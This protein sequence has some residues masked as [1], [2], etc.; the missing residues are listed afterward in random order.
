MTYFNKNYLSSI[1]IYLS[2]INTIRNQKESI[3]LYANNAF[4]AVLNFVSIAFLSH[5][6]L[7]QDYGSYKYMFMIISICVALGSLGFSQA[8]FYYIYQAQDKIE[9]YAYLNASRFCLILS[10]G[11]SIISF[12]ILNTILTVDQS[13]YAFNKF[14]GVLIGIIF[15]GIV[16]S[17]ELNVFLK[18]RCSWFYFTNIISSYIIRLMLFYVAYLYQADLFTY[19]NIWFLN[20]ILSTLINQLYLEFLYQGAPYKLSKKYILQI[21]KYSL[22]IG[23]A[24]FFGVILV[25]VDRVVLTFL[26][27]DP[28]KLAIV[29]NGNFEVPLITAFYA[30]F[31]TISFPKMLKAFNANNKIEMLK[32]R[33]EYQ[34]NVAL[35]LF[36][37]VLTF[38]FFSTEIMTVVF[39][40]FYVSSAKLFSIYSITFLFRFT[41]YH[42][43]FLISKKTKYI[44]YIQAAELIFH[45]ILTY[46]FIQ[47][48]SLIGASIA[49]LVTNLF[50]FF[51]A[52]YLGSKVIEMPLKALYP[53]KRLFVLLLVS[54]II[55]APF[56]WLII[57]MDVLYMKVILIATYTLIN[58]I[59]LYFINSKKDVATV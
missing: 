8:V 43:L 14:Y 28:I 13:G 51:I 24:L 16:Q 40:E 38:I 19:V 31:S 41:S 34:I 47:M 52:S 15:S 23:I 45:I 25:Q 29:S 10:F 17:I 21:I 39:G 33:Y 42:D 44:A 56:Y 36:P 11:I 32:Y 22:P 35:L 30:S 7:P 27:K 4:V 58:I 50:Y 12:Y 57:N 5:V 49:V 54:I 20:A 26:F 3:V 9:E 55:L 37:I 1:F 48:F 6:L 53:Y 18:N 2:V 46:V 59:T